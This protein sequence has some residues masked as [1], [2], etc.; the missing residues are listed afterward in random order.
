MERLDAGEVDAA[1]TGLRWT[2]DA[3]AIVTTRVLPDF[4]AALEFANRVGEL[5]EARNHHPDILI[6][7]NRV[8]LTLTTHD[9]GGITGLDVELAA[10]VDALGA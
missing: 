10:A 4:R 2:R 6:A 5:A 9:A 1:L 3:D 7:Y 8:S